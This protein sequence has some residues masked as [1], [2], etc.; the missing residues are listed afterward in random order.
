[1][2]LTRYILLPFVF[3]VSAFAL[4]AQQSL[5]SGIKVAD[6]YVIKKTGH[7]AEVNMNLDLT[8]MPDMNSNLLMAITPV[9]QSNVSDESVALKPI[10]LAGNSR[11]RIVN[12]HLALDKHYSYNQSENAPAL[13]VNRHNGKEQ[14]VV[15]TASTPYQPWMSNASMILRAENTGCAECPLGMEESPL[16][17]DALFP[18]YKADYK[19]DIMVPAGELVKKREEKLSARISFKVG[20]YQVLPEF[21]GNPAELKRIDNKLREL[22]GDNDIT[23]EKLSMV[24][25][26][27]PEGGVEY[28]MQLSKDRAHSF[29][30][31]LIRKH[32]ILK[33]RF[34]NSWKGQDWNG[35]REAVAKSNLPMRA[36]ILD[37]IDNKPVEERESALQA[38]D[39]GA[40]YANLLAD[41]YPSL[42]RSE[43]T[44]HIVVKGFQLDKARQIIKTYPTRLSLAEVYA[45]AQSYPEGSPERYQTWTIAEK[46]FPKAIEPTANAAIMDLRAG[47][48]DK[49]LERLEARWDEVKLWTLLGIAYAYNEKWSEAESFFS[50]AA[51]KG[52]P[53]AQYNLEELRHYMEDNF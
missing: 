5:L 46:A 51:Q 43:L 31:Y 19:F 25:Y 4:T 8:G 37:I 44:F 30:D 3:A 49:A 41:Y 9:I 26:A 14:F 36:A 47:R 6:K 21:D 17:T 18:L 11:Y 38:L 35:L 28:N 42:R 48:Y 16:S 34:E 29:A 23:F 12:R 20:K 13:V 39:G 33:G 24:G 7:T 45:V 32:S 40:V 1:M 10:L 52:M 53:D 27:S 15:Y 2:K 50:R 22:R